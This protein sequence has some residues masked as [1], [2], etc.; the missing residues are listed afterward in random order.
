MLRLLKLIMRLF[1][2]VEIDEGLKDKLVEIQAKLFEPAVKLVER[3]NLHVTLK[4]IGEVP[5]ERVAEIREA[6]QG[7]K[8]LP[9]EVEIGG[10]GTFP[11]DSDR[12][13]VV[14]V[15][16]KG[17]L[18]ELA[19]KVEEALKPLGFARDE[20]GFSSHLTLARV[21]Q[22]PERLAGV[23]KELASALVGKQLVNCFVL[24]RS[25][26]TPQGPIYEDIEVYKL[27]G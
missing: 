22:K 10:L 5:D 16:C 25:T 26:L 15:D 18:A 21:K 11:P 13:N 17:P 7:V 1:V 24:K 4:F 14:W 6:L 19:A 12:I 27:G 8:T 2:A 23:V 3:Q 20:R 9:F